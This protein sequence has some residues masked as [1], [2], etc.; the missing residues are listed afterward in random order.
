MD[1]F[2]FVFFVLKSFP[3]GHQVF[4]NFFP[5]FGFNSTNSTLFPFFLGQRSFGL[6]S[7]LPPL[8]SLLAL[9]TRSVVTLV[10]SA[11]GNSA[12]EFDATKLGSDSDLL[13]SFTGP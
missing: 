8:H 13:G 1:S 11:R 3:F 2:N 9:I 5:N 6:V 7:P 4:C 10:E 12:S